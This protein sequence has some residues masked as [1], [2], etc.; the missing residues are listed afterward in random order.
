M[1]EVY[2]LSYLYDP[3]ISISSS[4]G[5]QTR[6][7]TRIWLADNNSESDRMPFDFCAKRVIDDEHERP[8]LLR[9]YT[10]YERKKKNDNDRS[11]V[12]RSIEANGADGVTSSFL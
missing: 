2:I 3:L 11:K 12:P 1:R 7:H 5:L 4:S 6:P 8:S 9:P 10:K